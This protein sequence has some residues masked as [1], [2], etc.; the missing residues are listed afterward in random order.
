M[1]KERLREAWEAYARGVDSEASTPLTPQSAAWLAGTSA[2]A[3]GVAVLAQL[4]LERPEQR[5]YV[6][7]VAIVLLGASGQVLRGIGEQMKSPTLKAVG[8]YC[9]ALAY[10]VTASVAL[11]NGLPRVL[12]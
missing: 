1:I 5:I 9:G 11:I 3:G 4:L 6:G 8:Y 12:S 2:V 7:I 10:L